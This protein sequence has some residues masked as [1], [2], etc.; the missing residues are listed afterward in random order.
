MSFKN[1]RSKKKVLWKCIV[2]VGNVWS[3]L[4]YIRAPPC[5]HLQ[6][7]KLVHFFKCVV[8]FSGILL[9]LMWNTISLHCNLDECIWLIK[10]PNDFDLCLQQDDS[11]KTYSVI[12]L[13]DIYGFEVF[14]NNRYSGRLYN[15]HTFNIVFWPF[16]KQ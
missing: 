3:V 8:Y 11:S 5:G 9:Q 4:R 10:N 1:K 13:L 14:Q 6:L 12:G 7:Y 2:W 15:Q 16:I